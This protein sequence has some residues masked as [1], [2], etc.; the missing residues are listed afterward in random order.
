MTVPELQVV[1][2]IAGGLVT[3]VFRLSISS[4]YHASD[5]LLVR[6]CPPG[7][8][9]KFPVTDVD[10]SPFSGSLE[11]YLRACKQDG[12]PKIP[13]M[14]TVVTAPWRMRNRV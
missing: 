12:G 8:Q 4:Q 13:G 7:I 2:H 5:S 14:P 3:K 11:P 10:Q 1:I 9:K 6:I